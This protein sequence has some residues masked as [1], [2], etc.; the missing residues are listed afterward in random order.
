M[1]ALG[2]IYRYNKKGKYV[3]WTLLIIKAQRGVA[4][5]VFINDGSEGVVFTPIHE[6][7]L[8]TPYHSDNARPGPSK[9]GPYSTL[10]R[11]TQQPRT[12]LSWLTFSIFTILILGS[13]TAIVIVIIALRDPTPPT[14]MCSSKVE[15]PL[16]DNLVINCELNDYK[17][18]NP[19][20]VVTTPQIGSKPVNLTLRNSGE[21]RTLTFSQ[22][23]DLS[24]QILGSK[25]QCDSYGIHQI[26]IT[27]PGKD[28]FTQNVTVAMSSVSPN[29]TLTVERATKCTANSNVTDFIASCATW[30]G[31]NKSSLN[32]IL[33]AENASDID[34]ELPFKCKTNYTHVQGWYVNCSGRIDKAFAKTSSKVQCYPSL[35]I[36]K[37]KDLM[38][39][40]LTNNCIA[41]ETRLHENITIICSFSSLSWTNISISVY[42]PSPSNETVLLPND[43]INGW[44]YTKENENI[45]LTGPQASCS[46]EGMYWINITDKNESRLRNVTVEIK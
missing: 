4:N 28:V 9:E 8:K 21:N 23:S 12:K 45:T 24:V 13:I 44:K 15:I 5:P 7:N 2:M 36:P 26:S 33:I 42:N 11:E 32:L 29:V 1:K 19:T 34:F 14:P 27:V 40:N 43:T 3:K 25:M 41:K 38:P 17:S 39:C 35:G 22:S 37:T 20:I 18:F 10:Q 46:K 31:C 6:T 16:T 30:S